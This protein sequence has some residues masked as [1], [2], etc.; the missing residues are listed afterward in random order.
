MCSQGVHGHVPS[1]YAC[2]YTN[3][4]NGLCANTP[5]RAGVCMFAC[6]PE[7]KRETALLH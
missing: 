6:L 4:A 5:M 3:A 7:Y 1:P 2:Y